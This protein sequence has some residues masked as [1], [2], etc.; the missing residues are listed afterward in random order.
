[1]M[2]GD[3]KTAKL[4]GQQLP[5]KEHNLLIITLLLIESACNAGDLHSIMGW[6]ATLEKGMDTHSSIP[7]W[8]I[9][10]NLMS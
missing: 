10:W 4:A 7:A 8:K 2:R 5:F 3:S 6:V 9:A 1:M